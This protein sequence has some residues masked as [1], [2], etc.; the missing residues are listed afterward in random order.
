MKKA[1]TTA[2]YYFPETEEQKGR[3][4]V[5]GS[6]AC[7]MADFDYTRI[8]SRTQRPDVYLSKVP[9]PSRY[10]H[11][12]APKNIILISTSSVLAVDTGTLTNGF[13][14]QT[15]R[16]IKTIQSEQEVLNQ[17]TQDFLQKQAE[18]GVD[19]TATNLRNKSNWMNVKRLVVREE[20]MKLQIGE[21]TELPLSDADIVKL[22]NA[23]AD[24][25]LSDMSDQDLQQL[26]DSILKPDQKQIL[27][28]LKEYKEN[29]TI[30]PYF[31]E[32][33]LQALMDEL[34]DIDLNKITAKQLKHLIDNYWEKLEVHHRT[35]IS[36]DET[37]QSNIDNLDTLGTSE[38]DKK[39]T[40]TNE[41]GQEKVNYKKPVNEE[42]RNRTGELEELNKKRVLKNELK[43]L[44]IT[45]LIAGGVGFSIG[46]SV[47]LA[48]GGLNPNSMKHAF[49][50]GTKSGADAMVVSGG[51]YVLSRTIGMKASEVL[52]DA[53]IDKFGDHIPGT[54]LSNVASA[55]SMG[56]TGSIAIMVSMVYQFTKLKI[57]G[58][59]TKESLLRVGK[60]AKISF[61]IL[62]MSVIAQ[63]IWGGHIGM[64]V[65]ITA[66][67]IMT[68][69]Q[70]TMIVHDKGIRKKITI[71][72]VELCE[73]N[74]EKLTGN[75]AYA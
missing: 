18:N 32:A 51:S 17:Q 63:G 6:C 35:S 23:I 69:S 37:K 27:Q 61:A 44:G 15:T 59:S 26:I 73:P 36:S 7:E 2:K 47:Q 19:R 3:Y 57:Q 65:S 11:E 28:A 50:A 46:F 20:L 53:I 29:G 40:H 70:I 38:H 52:F 74:I 5:E 22:K 62:T 67:V 33:K 49:V 54:A 16:Y 14:E 39:H 58:Y 72:L 41:D 8:A 34:Q 75:F 31:Q 1:I 48:Q 56:V 12:N 55:V 64:V 60:S 25:N 42:E 30:S 10:E 9:K 43:G 66:G 13:N 24:K 71:Y 45:L 68:G 4:T 21:T